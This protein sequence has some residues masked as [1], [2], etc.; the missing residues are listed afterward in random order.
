MA[1]RSRW[2]GRLGCVRIQR[3]QPVGALVPT[4]LFHDDLLDT[5]EALGYS[6]SWS[7]SA[8]HRN[9]FLQEWERILGKRV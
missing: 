4:D 7:S 1:G 8:A 9:E 2:A 5:T 6:T 3:T